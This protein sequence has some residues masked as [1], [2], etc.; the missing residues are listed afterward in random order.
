MHPIGN[1]AAK[2]PV[3][4]GRIQLQGGDPVPVRCGNGCETRIKPPCQ[5]L[6]GGKK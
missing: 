3:G 5:H 6:L 4:I 2:L 1:F